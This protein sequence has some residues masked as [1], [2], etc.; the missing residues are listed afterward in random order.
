MLEATLW[1]GPLNT[2]LPVM[3]NWPLV[4]IRPL[5]VSPVLN[6]TPFSLLVSHP[7]EAKV[8]AWESSD[9]CRV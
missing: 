3:L 7:N 4:Q 2:G 8:S 6:Q 1:A 5:S 9:M